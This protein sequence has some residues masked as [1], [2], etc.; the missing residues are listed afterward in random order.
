MVDP[1]RPSVQPGGFSSIEELVADRQQH[2]ASVL[3]LFKELDVF[4]FTLGLT[5]TW[6]SVIDDAA[7]PTCPGKRFGDF[8]PD[9][10]VFRNLSLDENVDK[11]VHDLANRRFFDD[12]VSRRAHQER[13][14]VRAREPMS[15]AAS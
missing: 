7:F 11:P 8:D 6:C 1:F 4:V 14:A 3:T 12:P 15:F 10:Y 13:L 5:E 2:L 9:R